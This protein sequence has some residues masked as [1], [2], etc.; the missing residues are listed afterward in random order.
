M[1]AT[2][3]APDR[4]V[5]GTVETP[6]GPFGAALTRGGLVRLTLPGESSDRCAAWVRRWMPGASVV[7]EPGALV[8]LTEELTAYFEGELRAFTLPVD[9]HGTPFQV[10]VWRALQRISYGQ[11]RSY[12]ALAAEIGRPRAVRAVGAANGANPIPIVVPC[13]RVIGSNGTLTGYAGGLGLKGRLLRLEGILPGP[14]RA[15]V[16]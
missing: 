15:S 2:T 13:H 6:V 3:G 5:V 9:L 1:V 11:V 16:P 8:Q 14:S 7:E 4:V 12:A 10:D